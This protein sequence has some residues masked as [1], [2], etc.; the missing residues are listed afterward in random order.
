MRRILTA[1]VL[2]I[3]VLGL[4]GIS[5]A[6]VSVGEQAPGFTLK[7]QSGK[8][9][10][11]SDFAGKTVVLEWF[12]DGCP[13]VRKHYK[14]GAMNTLAKKY[15]AKGV[16]WLAINSTSSASIESNARA[17]KKMS[18]DRPILD[19]SSGTVG[20]AYGATNTPDMVVIDPAG[21]VVYKGAIDSVPSAD[22][23][24]I[25]GAKNFVAQA[26]D[27]VL[28]GKPVTQSQTKPYGCTVKYKD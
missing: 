27:E 11:L 15:E 10:S 14:T 8:S 2:A 21:K 17:A 16:V 9:V 23:D 28:A 6:G 24:D 26:L 18:I 1:S 13:F 19:D 4:A 25:A 3:G 12:N 20:H 5:R 7:D 22:P